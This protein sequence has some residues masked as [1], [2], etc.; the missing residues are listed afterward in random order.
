MHFVYKIM[1]KTK[2]YYTMRFVLLKMCEN[3]ILLSTLFTDS[4]QYFT[5]FHHD[6]AVMVY[7]RFLA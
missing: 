1:S 6:N 2:P 3:Y 4:S 7:W 5:E